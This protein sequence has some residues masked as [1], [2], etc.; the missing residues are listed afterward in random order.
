[1]RITL[2]NVGRKFNR[3]WIFRNINLTLES[4]NVYVITG[5]NGSG[6]STFLQIL[7]GNLPLTEGK[8]SYSLQTKIVSEDNI[9]R[10]ISV[11]SPYLE[12]IEELTLTEVIEFHLRFKQ[13]R[14]NLNVNSFIERIGLQ[15]SKDKFISNFSSGMK[16]RLKLGLACYSDTPILLLD[17]PTSNLDTT[18]IAWYQKLISETVQNRLVILCSNQ[19]YEYESFGNILHFENGRLLQ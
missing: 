13:L 12:L 3:D 5:P 10:H 7:A 1:M 4:G 17:E 2:D 8:I 16:T 6:K 11:A 14:D 15:R 18:G 9:F 19:V